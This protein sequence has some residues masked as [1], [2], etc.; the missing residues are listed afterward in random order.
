MRTPLAL[1][2]FA[3]K[4]VLDVLG[5]GLAVDFALEVVP[6]LARD[7]WERWAGD[8]DE[9]QRRADVEAAAHAPPAAV[10]TV[11]A[12]AVAEAAPPLREPLAL[13]LTQ[14]PATIR[15]ALRR[16]SDPS[17]TTLPPGR[18]LRTAEDLVAFLPARLPR[19]RPGDR[20]LP[21]ASRELVELLGMG[22]FGEVWK[23][24]DPRRP[25]APPV[26]LKFCLIPEARRLLRHEA[27]V[28]EQVQRH[29]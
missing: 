15:Q 10:R 23:A 21:G 26:A 22:G 17:G 9:P 18:P 6:E 5:G 8:R 13:Y 11:V 3:A 27:A 29:G 14:V 12:E 24:R 28:L 25:G 4:A 16:P 7:V 2:K 19:F 20:P 1:L